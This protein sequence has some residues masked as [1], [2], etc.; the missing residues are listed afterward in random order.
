ML[1]YT[2]T[3]NDRFY[4]VRRLKNGSLKTTYLTNKALDKR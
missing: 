3:I 2:F 4:M 1:I